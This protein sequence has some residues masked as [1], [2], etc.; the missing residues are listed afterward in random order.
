MSATQ[1]E[2]RNEDGSCLELGGE[3]LTDILVRYVTQDIVDALWDLE[4][5]LLR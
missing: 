3:R 2:R 4:Q 5:T 1:D